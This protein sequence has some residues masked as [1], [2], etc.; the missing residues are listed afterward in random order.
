MIR[1][2]PGSHV[3][4]L[5]EIL[6]VTGEIPVGSLALFGSQRVCRALITKLCAP[7]TI[8]NT[9]TGEKIDCR[10]LTLHGKGVK[11]SVRFYKAGFPVLDW[12]GAR[13]YYFTTFWKHKLP[14]DDTHVERNFRL[15][16]AVLLLSAAGC[17]FRPWLKEQFQSRSIRR[18]SFSQ[19][20]FYS[21]HELKNS[22]EELKKTQYAR[23]I[24][25]VFTED[26]GMTVYNTRNS[27]MK[28]NGMGEF[29]AKDAIQ[30]L[31]ALNTQTREI[32]S[33]ILFG[34]T[35]EVALRT[36]KSFDRVPHADLRFDAIYR[37]IH[38]IPLS[39]DGVGQLQIL[40]LP[41]WNERLLDLMFE[42]AQ[43]SY[44]RGAFEY[45]AHVDGVYV[46]AFF[47]GDLARLI[48][49]HEAVSEFKCRAELICF[50]FQV[51]LAKQVLGELVD[52]KTIDLQPVLEAL[53]LKGGKA[54][55][56]KT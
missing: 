56:S 5:C 24:G 51:G 31:A 35:M 18:L 9:E 17:E 54:F 29:K 11:K 23:F 39:A 4:R 42:P 46:F 32:H 50:P 20:C 41:D 43:R 27:I 10:L 12:F 45:D 28:W 1:F 33:A 8:L 53:G 49:F 22:G 38:F 40:L 15:A 47:D 16:E 7:Q 6:A 25:A 37:H 13:E 55:E 44:E 36:M 34:Q 21:S 14:S 26:A 48:R 52:I 3:R 2:Q 19:P 30:K